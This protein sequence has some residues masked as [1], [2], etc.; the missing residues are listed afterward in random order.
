MDTGTRCTALGRRKA[1]T[2]CLDLFEEVCVTPPPSIS[3]LPAGHPTDVSI[4]HYTP[5][6]GKTEVSTC[7]SQGRLSRH[8]R[9]AANPQSL[10]PMHWLP[11][12]PSF[13]YERKFLCWAPA[14]AVSPAQKKRPPTST[15][16]K[17]CAR[18]SATGIGTPQSLSAKS[19]NARCPPVGGVA[20]SQANTTATCVPHYKRLWP[21]LTPANFNRAPPR[22]IAEFTSRAKFF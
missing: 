11:S 22:E 9:L 16:L 7:A 10:G 19:C 18:D 2:Q 17:A 1:P 20:R 3:A 6:G 21:M 13:P 12:D 4:K 5:A 15:S 14:C 8:R